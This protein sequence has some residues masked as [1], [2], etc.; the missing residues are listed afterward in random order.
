MV[1]IGV[2]GT[3]GRKDDAN[4]MNQNLYDAMYGVLLSHLSQWTGA[5][6][7]L[8]SGGAAWADHLAVRAYLDKMSQHLELHFPANFKNSKF[9]ETTADMCPGRV[10]NWYHQKMHHK[11][12]TNSLHQLQRAIEAG[13]TYDVSS[14]FHARNHLVGKV[15]VLIAFT[16]GDRNYMG[17]NTSAELAGLKDGGTAHTWNSSEAPLRIHWDLNQL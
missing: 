14:G 11:T 10:A 2:I 17:S 3:A 5:E 9:I 8:V 6:T 4:R 7:T 15:D 16:F 13:A 1:R 12:N